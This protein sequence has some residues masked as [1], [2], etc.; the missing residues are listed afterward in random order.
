MDR[1]KA[2]YKDVFGVGEKYYP[3]EMT[4]AMGTGAQESQGMD[5]EFH[6][7]F[8][9]AKKCIGAQL[10]RSYICLSI[11]VSPQVVCLRSLVAV[12]VRANKDN[13]EE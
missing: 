8:L 11:N 9:V 2:C 10:S 3:L 4:Q 7:D 5:S 6:S 13:V 1:E 12:N